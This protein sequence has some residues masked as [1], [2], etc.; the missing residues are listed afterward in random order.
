MTF[1]T[2]QSIRLLHF[3]GIFILETVMHLL[4]YISAMLIGVSLG[5]IGGGGSILTVPVL[6]YLFHVHPLLATSYSLFTVGTASLIGAWKSYRTG[7]LHMSTALLF[8]STSIITVL[9]TRRLL[10]PHI[11]E[12]LLIG[13]H[14]SIGRETVIM[15]LF[16]VLMVLAAFSMIRVKRQHEE[17]PAAGKP[18]YILLMA[19]GL[20]IG[21]VT[22]I[23]GAGGGFLLI[24][25]L[26]FFVKLPVKEAIGTS[27]LIIAMNSLIGFMG[28][29]GV[30]AIDWGL[31][32]AVS[33]LAI[34]GIL[35]GTRLGRNINGSKLKKGFGWFVL[36][37]GTYII[38][39]N[40]LIF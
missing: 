27:L 5:L 15:M 39:K 16:A 33:A 4:G 13:E 32:G 35:I 28:D 38:L 8:G 2:E 29:I 37:M 21:F 31:L 22:G 40:I 17:I 12:Q 23:L 25:A 6:V 14:I 34:A 1:V 30:Y 36:A 11:P 7:F 24:P 9:L 18:A 3:C 10:L 20:L 26:V 19:Y